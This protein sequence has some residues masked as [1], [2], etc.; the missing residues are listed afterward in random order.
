MPKALKTCSKSNKSPNLVTLCSTSMLR[1][2]T[3]DL[4]RNGSWTSPCWI[5]KEIC[6]FSREHV[7]LFQSRT[8][9]LYFTSVC[10]SFA[11][12]TLTYNNKIKNKFVIIF[13]MMF[14]LP[15]IAML[16]AILYAEL[17]LEQIRI[18][19]HIRKGTLFGWGKQGLKVSSWMD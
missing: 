8:R 3:F 9:N 5:H 18:V 19:E 15:I 11:F 1:F 14:G 13:F 16:A 6:W 4:Y 2:F 7:T 12:P 17:K 10:W